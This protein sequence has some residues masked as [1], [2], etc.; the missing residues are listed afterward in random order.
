MKTAPAGRKTEEK[1]AKKSRLTKV[2]VRIGSA[3]GKADRTAHKI[4]S[5]G[6]VAKRELEDIAKQVEALKRQLIKTT[7]RLKRALR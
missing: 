6:H 3:M 1:M 4:A 2:A 7:E 5:A